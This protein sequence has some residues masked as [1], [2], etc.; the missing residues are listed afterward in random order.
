MRAFSAMATMIKA[1]SA[2]PSETRNPT[3]G[4]PMKSAM[5]E[6]WVEPAINAS[7]NTIT[8]MAGSASEAIITSRLEPMPPK[9]VPTSMP[10][11][12][13]EKPRAGQKRDDGDEVGRPAEH[14]PGGEGGN[15]G[16]GHP[17]GGDDQIGRDAEQPAGVF[18]QHRLFA[19]QPQQIAIGLE[20]RRAAAAQQPRLDL[21][22]EPGQRRRKRQHQQHLRA[23]DG[24]IADQSH[25][26][27]T[28]NKQDQED[29]DQHQI[30]P[31]GQELEMIEPFRRETHDEGHRRIE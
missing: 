4:D 5:V 27:A 30:A 17:G 28:N 6:S 12:R 29:E 8:I 11:K 10:A 3:S 24:E 2:S 1:I 9:L 15:Q 20:K 26:A 31:D 14:Q 19:Q 23:L 13:Q 22:H 21:A 25:I 18:R 7:V 16:R